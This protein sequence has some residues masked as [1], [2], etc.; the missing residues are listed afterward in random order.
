MQELNAPLARFL[1]I[2]IWEV[3]FTLSKDERP[4]R[5]T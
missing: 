1:M 3:L 2:P 4:Y 5:E